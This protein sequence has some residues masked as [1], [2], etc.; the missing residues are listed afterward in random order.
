MRT[1][2]FTLLAAAFVTGSAG[3]VS[4]AIPRAAIASGS[5]A[6]APPTAT[7]GASPVLRPSSAV[8]VPYTAVRH[9]ELRMV[10]RGPCGKAGRSWRF[11]GCAVRAWRGSRGGAGRAEGGGCGGGAKAASDAGGRAGTGGCAGGWW[12]GVGVAVGVDVEVVV[13]GGGIG[14]H[15]P[16]GAVTASAVAVAGT[17]VAIGIDEEDANAAATTGALTPEP[18]RRET[19]QPAVTATITAI[20]ALRA[21]IVRA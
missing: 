20:A 18:C 9:P 1:T 12:V 6:P 11:Y 3:T 15:V 16:V 8:V 2:S 7:A 4:A 13:A 21:A 19:R 10:R 17:G 5:F 14:I